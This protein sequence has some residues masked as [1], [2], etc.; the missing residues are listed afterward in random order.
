MTTM[1]EPITVVAL[2]N[3]YVPGKL[4]PFLACYNVCCKEDD[5]DYASSSSANV[6]A[7]AGHIHF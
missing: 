6:I 7:E 5:D 3:K 2:F 1:F 4:V